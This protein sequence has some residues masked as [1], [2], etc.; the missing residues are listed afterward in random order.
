MKYTAIASSSPSPTYIAE[1]QS[2]AACAI[3]DSLLGFLKIS[4]G[5]R[6]A[7]EDTEIPGHA[8]LALNYVFA[9]D[10]SNARYDLAR[11]IK[12][13][14]SRIPGDAVPFAQ[15]NL[16]NLY[17]FGRSHPNP[18]YFWNHEEND[19]GFGEDDYEPNMRTVSASLVN[20]LRMLE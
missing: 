11:V 12:T 8:D 2:L 3:P 10:P 4:N 9:I 16:G 18:V 7:P 1:T 19:V 5:A 17:V 13:M 6:I 20:F 15:D 14:R